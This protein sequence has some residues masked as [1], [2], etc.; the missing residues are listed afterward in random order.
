MLRNLSVYP[1]SEKPIHICS[2]SELASRLSDDV[3]HLQTVNAVI[4]IAP[5]LKSLMKGW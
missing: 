3:A 5:Q 1:P 4:K 2:R